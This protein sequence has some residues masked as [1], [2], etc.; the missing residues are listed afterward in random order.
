MLSLCQGPVNCW[1]EKLEGKFRHKVNLCSYLKGR[2]DRRIFHIAYFFDKYAGTDGW[3]WQRRY[4]R[5]R[6]S[7]VC[8]TKKGKK[9]VLY[10]QLVGTAECI[11]L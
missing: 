1:S 4:I 9:H 7:Y 2:G 8:R 10:G 3:Q 5:V 6:W 11:A